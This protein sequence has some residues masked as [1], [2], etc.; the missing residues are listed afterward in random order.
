MS[1]KNWEWDMKNVKIPSAWQHTTS[2]KREKFM[3][4]NGW[5]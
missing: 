5:L 3:R 1:Y 4:E 2:A